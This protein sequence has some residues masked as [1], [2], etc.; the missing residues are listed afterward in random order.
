MGMEEY[1]ERNREAWNEVAPIHRKGRKADLRQEAV[2]DSFNVLEEVE[3]EALGR[4]GVS[5][6]SVAQLCCNNGRD[7]KIPMEQTFR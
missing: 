5:G 2:Q 1:A 7:V 6:K 4:I 3:R